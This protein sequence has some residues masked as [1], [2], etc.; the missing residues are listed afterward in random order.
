M[1]VQEE[2][3][4]GQRAGQNLNPGGQG[5]VSTQ[6]RRMRERSSPFQTQFLEE[7]RALVSNRKKAPDF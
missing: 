5:L 3:N 6:D 7:G 4:G 2:V 1:G